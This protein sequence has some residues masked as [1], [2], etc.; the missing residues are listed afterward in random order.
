MISRTASYLVAVMVVIST[1]KV[2]EQFLTFV[3]LLLN[4]DKI[5]RMGLDTAVPKL[6]VSHI[7]FTVPAEFLVGESVADLSPTH[8]TYSTKQ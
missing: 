2:V 4:T 7:V 1:A 3:K 5:T 6:P 8:A